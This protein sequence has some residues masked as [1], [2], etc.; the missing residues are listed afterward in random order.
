MPRPDEHLE[1][2]AKN[3]A[4]PLDAVP[5]L[6]P[7]IVSPP[8][9]ADLPGGVTQH[10]RRRRQAAPGRWAPIA[11]VAVG[12]I[13]FLSV[14]TGP[15]GLEPADETIETPSITAQTT[16]TVPAPGS[17]RD[18]WRPP[19]GTWVGGFAYSSARPDALFGP[20]MTAGL[21][22]LTGAIIVDSLPDGR[23]VGVYESGGPVVL[24]G[25]AGSDQ[26]A[27][28]TPLPQPGPDSPPPLLSPNGTRLAVI[29]T[30]G[31]PYVWS[32]DA[33]GDPENDPA[34][35]LQSTRDSSAT[36]VEAIASLTWSPDSTLLALNAFQGGYY[37]WNLETNE[38]SR[39]SMP[40]RAVAVSNTQVAAWGNNGLE[41]RDPTGRVLR[42]WPDL[43]PAEVGL[44]MAE[45]A[46]DPLSRYLAVRGLVG[47]QEEGREGLTV[48]ST[49]GTTRRVL[50]T[51]AA[52]GFA[53]SGDG[54]GLYWLD[55]DGLQVWSA[56]PERA[57]ASM[58]GGNGELFAR[59]RVYDPAI[60]PITHPALVTSSLVELRNGEISRRTMNGS[61]TFFTGYEQATI[62]PADLG[63]R[64]LTVAAGGTDRTVV[65][66][67]PLNPDSSL[68]LGNLSAAQLGD[69]GR[70]V[71]SV[72]LTPGGNDEVT[73]NQLE[74]TRWYLE[75][76][77]GSIL[78]GPDAGL[79]AS[80]ADGRALSFVGGTVF[81]VTQDGS[82][83]HTLPTA[84]GTD[85]LLTTVDLDAE[86]I[87]A[88][89][90]IRRAVFVLVVT[91]AGDVQIWQVP[92]DSELLAT[93]LFPP[94]PSITS[95]AWVVYNA[96]GPAAGGTILAEPNA[97]GGEVFAARIDRPDGPVTVIM[98]APLALESACG[99]SAGGACVLSETSGSPLGFSPDGTWLL[100]E[101]GDRYLA[102]STVGRGTTP[103]PDV[104]PDAVAWVEAGG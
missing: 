20:S 72:A 30:A 51:D 94:A 102:V 18:A 63:G 37:L 87:L 16:T 77:E 98:A 65:L 3:P 88:V 14:L 13:V 35:G 92:A 55:S 79:F 9:G 23:L 62:V 15:S 25:T 4:P 47:P 32:V 44:L 85:T 8:S 73:S 61:E 5:P 100:V 75:T 56:D 21:L 93:P 26:A 104:P 99:A 22:D 71:Q 28:L 6:P 10:G 80:V 95:W 19:G 76:D 34:L 42:R 36:A 101:D 74:A 89:G 38:V 41:L 60:S 17:S 84:T 81:S 11:A 91:N 69:E 70:I 52:Q 7:P 27:E 90:V 49:I 46:F 96:P 54:S 66:A 24:L 33:G 64:F 78:F 40:G 2:I 48:L 58:L 29:D 45:G 31:V 67:D 86:S 97:V 57:S 1:G 59:L 39:D 68:I 43:L 83:I 12:G 103:L 53:W 50:T 82:A